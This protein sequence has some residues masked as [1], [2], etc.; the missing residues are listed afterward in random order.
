M[1]DTSTQ[2]TPAVFEGA[3]RAADYIEPPA[4]ARPRPDRSRRSQI[5]EP[6][7]AITPEPI[8]DPHDP[9]APHV[10]PVA[11]VAPVQLPADLPDHGVAP[12]SGT[13][14]AAL[15]RAAF[16][17]PA[18][19]RTPGPDRA[20]SGLRGVLARLG[21]PVSPSAREIAQLEQDADR[22]RHETTIRQ[23]TWTRAVAV[24][25]ANP[26][27]GS[28]KTPTALLLG[29]V[30]A[31]IRGGSVAV[32]EVAD[33]PGALAFRAEGTPALGVGELVRDI[34]SITNAGQLAGYTAPQT[35]FAAVIGST[36]RRTRLTGD[37]VIDAAGTIDEFYAI[38]VMDSGNQPT[39]SAFTGALTVTDALVVP[40][41]NAGDSVLEAIQL[42][43]ELRSAGRRT[44][45]L[46]DHA[47]AVRLT[48]GRPEPE[49]IRQEVA[50]LLT[51]AGIQHIIDVPYDPHIA[52]RG[53]L[54]L[55]AVN[56]ATRA[57]FVTAAAAVVTTLQTTI[58]NPIRKA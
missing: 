19:S 42:L 9:T 13:E 52:E 36:G 32:L 26:K 3:K 25:V 50:R 40:L 24:L 46:A 45:E 5:S 29:G 27:G 37:A 31:A 49:T 33:D 14:Q 12:A 2:H 20:R 54:T 51:D 21:L 18:A 7:A 16:A 8:H 39:S 56:P 41:M 6:K 15:A 10:V 34:R 4:T 30:L 55:A 44:A 35:S 58:R 47:I 48:D 28:G 22:V 38:R 1:T 57:A 11:A 23:A 43:D 17:Q 53:Q